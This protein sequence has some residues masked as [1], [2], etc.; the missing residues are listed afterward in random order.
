M[1]A[2]QLC[3]SI[4]R[5]RHKMMQIE[6]QEA[7]KQG[8]QMIELRL[9]FLAK[10]PDFKRLLIEKPCPLVATVRRQ[11]DGGRWSGTEEQRQM[12]LRQ[13]IVGGF[14]WVDLETDIAEKIRRFGQVKR[15]ISYHNFHECP[16][17][18]EEIHAGMCKQDPDV[19]KLAVKAESPT[20]NIR[21]MNLVNKS[22]TP[23]VALCMGDLGVPSRILGGK[24]GA[25]FSYCAFNKERE[26]APGILS[27]DEMKDVYH[28][29]QINADTKVYGVIGDPLGHSLSPLLHNTAFRK[30]GLN[31]VYVPFRVPRDYDLESFLKA[32]DQFPVYGY[33]VTIPHK[34]AAA[35]VAYE[36]DDYVALTKAANTLVR[37]GEGA[38]SAYNTDCSAFVDAVNHGLAQMEMMAQLH[39]RAVLLLGAG[40]A[41]R[42]IAHALQREK[43]QVTIA[44]RDAKRAHKLAE[45][46]GCKYVDWSAR[47]S[48]VCEMVVNATAVGMHPNVD[49]S[50][51]HPSF[52]RTGLI[53]FDAVY[54]PET[55]L[56]IKEARERDCRVMTGVEMFVRQAA[57]QVRLFTGQEASIEMLRKI[58]RRALSPLRV[59]EDEDEQHQAG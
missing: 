34:E 10:A 41:A 18:L 20:D 11:A 47:H 13:V 38:W 51:V 2:S 30:M 49:E 58:V 1:A 25:P 42:A 21:V 23:T 12:L 19:V 55:T 7:A 48:V 26:L 5:T 33:S 50:P 35:G 27:Y 31:S 56:L 53:V 44:N 14:D 24:F 4:G 52:Y 32:F 8:A 3:V 17:N 57:E 45:E 40:G 15:I 6:I 39:G 29:D 43:A 16:K 36:K 28:Y 54:N 59:P 37:R 46:V 22:S 9:D